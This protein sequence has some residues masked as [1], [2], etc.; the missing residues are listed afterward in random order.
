MPGRQKAKDMV[1]PVG[2]PLDTIIHQLAHAQGP[3][4]IEAQKALSETL[5]HIGRSLH[6]PPT[7]GRPSHSV[8]QTPRGT[9]PSSPLST[10]APFIGM[11]PK[12]P[13]ATPPST[14]PRAG[15]STRAP[16][17]SVQVVSEALPAALYVTFEAICY[18]LRAESGIIY[19]QVP[20]TDQLSAVVLVGYGS[21][22]PGQ[23]RCGVGS[24]PAGSVLA[25]GIALHCEVGAN[26]QAASLF[27]PIRSLARHTEIVGVV[28]VHGKF[29]GG[30]HNFTE[31]DE[32]ALLAQTPILSY[33][34]TRFPRDVFKGFFDP[35][36]FLSVMPF[37]TFPPMDS[38]LP[39]IVSAHVVPQTVHRTVQSVAKI[40][41]THLSGNGSNDGILHALGVVPSLR[42]ISSYVSNLQECWRR[43]VNINVE[44]ER[45]QNARQEHVARIRE[46]LR[47][48]KQEVS[49]LSDTVRVHNMTGEDYALEYQK[50]QKELTMLVSLRKGNH[51]SSDD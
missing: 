35:I 47:Q 17:Q 36:H 1:D 43:S 23:V 51:W 21:K 39:A 49:K 40:R 41:S 4:S 12:K 24:S 11:Q 20:G 13:A 3:L 29:R 9:L 26:N 42:E 10:L 44:L 15:H 14:A 31:Q 2:T 8:G 5:A 50:L 34:L 37:E 28:Q 32:Q 6:R 27:F 25:T 22:P 30:N 38:I 45:T 16:Q 19:M 7:V 46:E 18:Q 48:S 33:L